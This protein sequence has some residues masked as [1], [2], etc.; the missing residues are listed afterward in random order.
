MTKGKDDALHPNR[1]VGRERFQGSGGLEGSE[2]EARFPNLTAI[3]VVPRRDLG[4]VTTTRMSSKYGS[5]SWSPFRGT[6]AEQ[7][8][9]T[10]ARYRARVV[11]GERGS[12]R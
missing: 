8:E 3:G 1:A 2:W 5:G 11:R 12:A 10:T 9:L 7:G 4:N 6:K